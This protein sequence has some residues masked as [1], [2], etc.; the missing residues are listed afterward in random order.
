MVLTPT[1]TSPLQAVHHHQ[2]S[3]HHLED[4]GIRQH[5]AG[6]VSMLLFLLFLAGGVVST[7]MRLR[8]QV[9]QHQ[10]EVLQHRLAE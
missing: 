7:T 10:I 6:A 1:L 3:D 4:E 8:R 5:G 9:K 2:T